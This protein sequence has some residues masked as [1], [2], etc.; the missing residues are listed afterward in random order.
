MIASLKKRV[1]QRQSDHA[2]ETMEKIKATTSRIV[3][4]DLMRGYFLIVI[5]LNHLHYYPSGLEWITGQSYLYASTA[6]GFFL[7]SGIVLGIV[8]GAKLLDKPFKVARDLLLRRSLQ[9]YITYI[10]LL[11]FFTIVGWFFLN[12]PGLKFGDYLPQGSVLSFL[13]QVL[14]FQYVYG[15]A[16]YLRMYALFIL[17]SPLALWLLRRGQWYIVLVASFIIWCLYPFSPWPAGELSEPVS[18]QLIFFSG[19]V[20]GFH[21]NHITGWWQ[22]LSATLKKYLVITIWTIAFV[23]VTI[24]VLIVFGDNLPVIGHA[25]AHYDDVYS[26]Y[27]NKDRLP[28]VR[29]A[30]FTVWF[31]ALAFLFQKFEPWL[32]KWLGWLLLAFGTNSLYTYTIQAFVVFFLMLVMTKE[33]SFWLINLLVSLFAIGVVYL[34]VRTK[35]LMKIIPR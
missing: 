17:L 3:T 30:L 35:F 9:L 22:R 8:R 31:L 10:I 5:L 6:E 32:K 20:I 12:D 7:I 27:F 15:W 24:N 33:S 25:L 11:L 23:T 1:W 2:K 28:L 19:F 16:D 29:L 26:A 18:W 4:L 21:F 13:W 14:T 34:C